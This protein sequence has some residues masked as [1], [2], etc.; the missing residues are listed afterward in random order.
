MRM[1]AIRPILTAMG[2]F[3]F[4]M[5]MSVD[6]YCR[7]TGE[8]PEEPLGQGGEQLHEWVADPAGLELQ[9]AYG[10][11]GAMICGRRTYEDSLPF[12]GSDGPTG[13][14]ANPVVIVT[15][16]APKEVPEGANYNFA[17]GIEDA[18][19]LARQ[20][21]GDNNISVM[22]PDVARQYLAAGLIDEIVVHLVPVLF[23]G[24]LRMF[25]YVGDHIQLETV[26]VTNGPRATHVTYRVLK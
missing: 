3:V 8:T 19:R 5:S 23:G 26:N 18:L 12:W 15:H 24:G 17:T 10:T 1:G 22:G 13:D 2:K 11:F 25:D 9:A 6:G 21:A 20:F 14:A 16:E 7:A 4:D